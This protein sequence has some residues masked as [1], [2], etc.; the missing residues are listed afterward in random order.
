MAFGKG[1]FDEGVFLG[2]RGRE[3][4]MVVSSTTESMGKWLPATDPRHS[5]L[6]PFAWYEHRVVAGMVV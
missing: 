3:E 6:G 2:G 4:L 1:T 5:S